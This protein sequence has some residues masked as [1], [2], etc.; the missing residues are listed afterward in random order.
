M[1]CPIDLDGFL[2]VKG[3]VDIS[4]DESVEELKKVVFPVFVF[5]IRPI[6]IGMIKK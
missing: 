1:A 6:L 5:P 4:L 2:V 3:Y